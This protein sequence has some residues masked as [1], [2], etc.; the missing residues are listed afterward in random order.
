MSGSERCS[1]HCA[2][3]AASALAQCAFSMQ[4]VIRFEKKLSLIALRAKMNIL[5]NHASSHIFTSISC[6]L[7]MCLIALAEF[8]IRAT[9][10]H[11]EQE[12]EALQCLVLIVPRI[13]AF[14]RAPSC[15]TDRS[16]CVRALVIRS[17]NSSPSKK[18]SCEKGR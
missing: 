1:A 7:I 10:H 15:Q 12:N 8:G 16:K 3:S 18:Y 13:K 6:S 5:S 17:C 9:R 4:Y 11:L 14:L 2:A